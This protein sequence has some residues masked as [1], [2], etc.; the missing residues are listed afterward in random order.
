MAWTRARL[1]DVHRKVWGNHP[2]RHDLTSQ[3]QVAP[4]PAQLC[5]IIEH[6]LWSP[7][8]SMMLRETYS[9]YRGNIVTYLQYM[10]V[11]SYTIYIYIYIHTTYKACR[12]SVRIPACASRRPKRPPSPSW[13]IY[14]SICLSLSL[15]LY[16]YIYIYIQRERE[17]YE[18]VNNMYMI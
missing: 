17:M 2:E 1:C 3:R 11:L 13:Q 12:K 8:V 5:K 16:I 10:Y 18:Y 6:L 7:I 14:L 15:S 9:I 4:C